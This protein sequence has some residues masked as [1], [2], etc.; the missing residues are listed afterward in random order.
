M[1][2]VN[3]DSIKTG[4]GHQLGNIGVAR[5]TP[6]LDSRLALFPEFLNAICFHTCLLDVGNVVPFRAAPLRLPKNNT[7]IKATRVGRETQERGTCLHPTTAFQL[8]KWRTLCYNKKIIFL[9]SSILS[10]VTSRLDIL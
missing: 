4:V 2:P 7:G 5:G 8:P 9:E 1:L 6:A 3:D 10:D